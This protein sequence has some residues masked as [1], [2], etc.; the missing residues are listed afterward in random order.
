M[1]QIPKDYRIFPEVRVLPMAQTMRSLEY[2]LESLLEK[3]VFSRMDAWKA[4]SWYEDEADQASCRARGGSPRV[5][6]RYVAQVRTP[7]TVPLLQLTGTSR[8]SLYHDFGVA[9]APYLICWN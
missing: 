2:G 8:F 5:H 1:S 7:H 6:P 3:A 4:H 9:H